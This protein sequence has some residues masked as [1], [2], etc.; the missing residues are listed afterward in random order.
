MKSFIT[1]IAFLSIYF[2]MSAFTPQSMMRFHCAEDTTEI[3]SILAETNNR[4]NI[5][6]LTIDLAKHFIGRKYKAHTLEGDK[7]YLTINIHEFDCVTFVESIIALTQTA[8]RSHSTWRDYAQNLESIRYRKGSMTGYA[9]RLHYISDWIA[10]NTYRGNIKEITKSIEGATTMIKTLNYM[11]RNANNYSAL[12]DSSNLAE[13]KKVE[14]GYRSHLIPCL[15]KQFL[16][17]KSVCQQLKDGDIVVIL[18]KAEGLDASHVGFIAFINNV[19]HLLHA[20]T[21]NGEI[22]LEQIDLN[23]YLKRH[24][25]NAPGVRI[26]RIVQ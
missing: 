16:A 5:E 7:E 6:S 18:S 1:L 9:S 21:L 17:K 3:N 15:K 24:A 19:P 20:S 14:M 8:Q 23:E 4:T 22:H 12:E 2:S 25:R 13:I 26:L 10:D 11:S